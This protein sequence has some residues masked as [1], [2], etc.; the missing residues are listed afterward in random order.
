MGLFLFG[1]LSRN[2]ALGSGRFAP[3]PCDAL[4]TGQEKRYAQPSYQSFSWVGWEDSHC[5]AQDHPHFSSWLRAQHSLMRGTGVPTERQTKDF[6]Y[7]TGSIG[8]SFVEA[9]PCVQA[10]TDLFI[11]C[12]LQERG[13]VEAPLCSD[14]WRYGETL[15]LSERVWRQ[16]RPCC[17]QSIPRRQRSV[18]RVGDQ[19]RSGGSTFIYSDRILVLAFIPTFGLITGSHIIHHHFCLIKFLRISMRPTLAT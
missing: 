14:E 12:M 9:P 18:T 6:K 15:L 10:Q 2:Q 17:C 13:N 1:L 8:G 5:V 16:S 3:R 4:R 7:R 19:S 11:R